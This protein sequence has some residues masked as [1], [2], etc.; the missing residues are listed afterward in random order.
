M[1]K[2]ENYRKLKILLLMIIMMKSYKQIKHKKN[3]I[4]KK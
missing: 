4:S 1:T 2:I 3:N